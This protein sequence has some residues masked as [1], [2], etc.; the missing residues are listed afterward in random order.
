MT[1]GFEVFLDTQL[2]FRFRLL[3][4]DGGVLAVSCP[5]DSKREAAAGIAALREC[6]GMGLIADLSSPG[7][8]RCAHHDPSGCQ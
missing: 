3:D 7:P 1:G 8:V 6:A 4:D 5:F 2:R